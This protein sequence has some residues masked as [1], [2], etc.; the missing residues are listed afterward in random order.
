MRSR[1]IEKVLAHIVLACMTCSAPC[2][3]AMRLEGRSTGHQ[4]A[5]AV[6]NRSGGMSQCDVV[7]PNSKRRSHLL[8]LFGYDCRCARE[9][10]MSGNSDKCT[11]A[12]VTRGDFVLF[13]PRNLLPE[14]GC[15]CRRPKLHK[16]SL[17]R[18]GDDG[19]ELKT[20][21]DKWGKN[22]QDVYEK[23]DRFPCHNLTNA[24]FK[25]IVQD[26]CPLTCFNGCKDSWYHATQAEAEANPCKNLDSSAC[27]RKVGCEWKVI[28]KNKWCASNGSRPPTP[29]PRRSPIPM[30]MPDSAA[31]GRSTRKLQPRATNDAIKMDAPNAQTDDRGFPLPAVS[32]SRTAHFSATRSESD[33]ENM[34]IPVDS[35]NA[36]A[37]VT[38]ATSVTN[39][40]VPRAGKRNSNMHKAGADSDDKS[41]TSLRSWSSSSLMG[42]I[43]A[44]TQLSLV[45]HIA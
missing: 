10:V 6:S 25:P 36:G 9:M 41:K 2:A 4:G 40:S 30:P 24:C 29:M 8:R 5:R 12:A 1:G 13:S 42:I 7:V 26:S 45:D 19:K 23:G 18:A 28:G 22:V 37:N 17:S 27:L 21:K 14:Y 31:A 44:A 3:S 43:L 20:C 33:E 16:G 15:T 32:H 35:A 39:V 11:E 38:N 34:L